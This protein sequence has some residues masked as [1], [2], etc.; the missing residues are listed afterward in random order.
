MK[1][2]GQF[3]KEI[4]KWII[5]GCKVHPRSWYRL[6][7]CLDC[8]WYEGNSKRCKRCGCYMPLKTKLDTSKC[9]IEKW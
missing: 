7:L 9:P 8:E 2:I 3:V 1:K 5:K 6:S 4:V